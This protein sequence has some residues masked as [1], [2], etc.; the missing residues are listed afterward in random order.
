MSFVLTAT[1]HNTLPHTIKVLIS[2]GRTLIVEPNQKHVVSGAE[3]S[4]IIQMVICPPDADDNI[5]RPNTP[6]PVP[7]RASGSR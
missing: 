5:P 1:V 3:G 2:T 6:I 7:R 4:K